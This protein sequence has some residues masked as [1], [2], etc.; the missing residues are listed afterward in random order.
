MCRGTER[1][2]RDERPAEPQR[3]DTAPVTQGLGDGALADA[4]AAEV[5]APIVVAAAAP[6]SA[7]PAAAAMEGAAVEVRSPVTAE[8][9][10]PVEA[11]VEAKAATPAPTPAPLAA[12][13]ASAFELPIDSL[14]AIAKSAG[15]QWV[16]SDVDKIRA[17]QAALD[18]Q[19]AP[20]RVPRER[21]PVARLDD[22]PLV[23]VETRK[24]LSQYKLPFET[25]PQPGQPRE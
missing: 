25:A 3:A 4:A 7:A 9:V 10:S 21:K 16:N 13:E 23:L 19:P 20:A 14:E 15:L 8:P 2:E 24:D 18:S 12:P 1:G 6:F 5:A 17:V 11:K 22:G